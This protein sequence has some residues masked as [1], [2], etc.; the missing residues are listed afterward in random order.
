MGVN[1]WVD[2]WCDS[3]F[4]GFL[5]IANHI[6]FI[7]KA[8]GVSTTLKISTDMRL[9]AGTSPLNSDA[10]GGQ[11]EDIQEL[12]IQEVIDQIPAGH[13]GERWPLADIFDCKFGD[14]KIQIQATKASKTSKIVHN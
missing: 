10:V 8:V 7:K 14:I 13:R 2:Q 1:V 9:I 4:N 5:R 12:E 11:F 6:D 3:N